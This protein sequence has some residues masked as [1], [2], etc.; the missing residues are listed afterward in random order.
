MIHFQLG[1]QQFYIGEKDFYQQWWL[2]IGIQVSGYEPNLSSNSMH[3][4]ML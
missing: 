4:R 1:A 3:I 2:D